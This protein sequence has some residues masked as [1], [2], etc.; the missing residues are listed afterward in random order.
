MSSVSDPVSFRRGPAMPNRLM[1]APLTNQQSHADGTL[2]DDE[3]HWLRMRAEGGFGLTMTC[4][5]HVQAAGQGFAGQLGVFGDEHLPGLTRLAADLNATGTVS[6]VQL[7]HAGMRSP[8]DLIGT[9]PVCP[10]DDEST[11]ARALTTA[12]VEQVRD[13][14]VAAAVRAQQAGFHG[15]ELHGAHGY[16]L[17]QFLSSEV[18][19][20]TDHFGGSLENRSRLL[21]EIVDGIRAACGDD[22]ALAV[23]LSPERFGMR[24]SEI[25]EVYGRLVDAGQVDLIDMSLWDVRRVTDEPGFDDRSLMEVFA[26][27]P[28]GEVR[29]GVAGKIHTPKDVQSVLDHGVDVPVLGRVAILHHD[30]PARLLADPSFEPRVAPVSREVLAAEGVSPSFIEYLAGTFRMVAD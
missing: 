11:G 13:D 26:A 17:C 29:L 21:F 19:R 7:H 10:S 24:T 25:V 20:R 22:L 9:Q 30:Y 5:A 18:N 8:A 27:L 15:V 23:R 16:L 4:A 6:F 28:R 3:H 12:E 1:L 2:S 14:F